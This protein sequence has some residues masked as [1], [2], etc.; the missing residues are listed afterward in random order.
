MK[1]NYSFLSGLF[2]MAGVL[3]SG[4]LSAEV[5]LPKI[6]SD[7]MMFQRNKKIH[8]WGQGDP[9]E[10][11]RVTFEDKTLKT[12]AGKQ[13]AWEVYLPPMKAGGPYQLEV[14]GEKNSLT[15]SDILIGDIWICSGQSNM[16]FPI[17]GSLNGQ[18]E[19]K[20]ANYPKIRIFKVGKKIATTPQRD[21][22]SGEWKVCNPENIIGFSAV[23]FFFGRYLNEN[24]DV[25]IGLIGS[26]WGG[27]VVETWISKEGLAG[28][29]TFGKLAEQVP[30]LD[31][32]KKKK[33]MNT[34]HA[35]WI[36]QFTEKDR[37]M[38]DGKYLWAGTETD[39][40]SWQDITLPQ[41]WEETGISDLHGL[42]GVVWFEKKIVLN[43][44]QAGFPALL[45]LGPIDDSDISWMNGKKIGETDNIYNQERKYQIPAGVLKPGE[46]I[47]VV[48]VEDYRG[49]GGLFGAPQQLFLRVGDQRIPL[50]GVWKYKIGMKTSSP[51]PGQVFGPN[52][53][54]TLLYNG[55]IVPLIP[56]PVKGVIW[57]Q[58]ESNASRAYQYRDLFKRLITDWRTKWGEGDFP[59]LWVQLAN[60]MTPAERPVESD[61]AE[62]REAQDMALS[63]PNTGEACA[64]DIGEADDIHPKNKQEVGRRLGLA[65]MKVAYHRDIL[66]T[67]PRYKNM[68]VRDGAVYITFDH[69]GKGLEVKDKYGCVKGFTIAGSDKKF[70]WAMAEI[71]DATTVKVYAAAV[72]DPVAVR[73]AWANNPDQADL[74]NSAGLPAC[75]FRTDRWKGITWGIK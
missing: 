42:D 33:E 10:R 56:L 44:Q 27:T 61:W 73:Y 46:N 48:R 62:L 43:E 22:V 8:I 50:D 59:F 17:E 26:Y 13:G 36:K 66:Y 40:S 9:G 38:K 28:E 32:E 60:F 49:Y 3:F 25:P 53:L 1:R 54:P 34:E 14:R 70:H 19:V 18:E 41:A 47:L 72:P 64:I 65:A 15:F 24:F 12:K 39:Y 21:V 45:S 35:G 69:T 11:V 67:G 23:G 30:A 4:T 2:L 68:E 58:G 75:P 74:Y 71:V 29:P 63:L 31:I 20:N 51:D 16:E 5:T 57:Y 7:H 6:F 55:M 52:S 37:G